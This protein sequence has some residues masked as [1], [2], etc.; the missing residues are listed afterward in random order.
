MHQSVLNI[1]P[2]VLLLVSHKRL[3][4]CELLVA[5]VARKWL[6]VDVEE[7][8]LSQLVCGNKLAR[9]EDT[10]DS[11]A[12]LVLLCSNLLHIRYDSDGA[13][14]DLAVLVKSFWMLVFN[15]SNN[16]VPVDEVLKKSFVRIFPEQVKSKRSIENYQ[17]ALG[18]N[19]PHRKD[20][21]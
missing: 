16:M 14:V 21:T 17:L 8:V 1:S 12:N 5:D 18:C 3:F 15:V 20:G 9:T 11:P 4:D 19:K 7:N 13:F 10:I 2:V 6:V